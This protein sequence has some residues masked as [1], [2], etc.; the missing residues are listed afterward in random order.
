MLKA[1]KASASVFVFEMGVLAVT[2]S[3]FHYKSAICKHVMFTL[4]LS[5]QPALMSTAF[6][7]WPAKAKL[8][9]I[10]YPHTL[11]LLLHYLA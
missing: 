4:R 7:V 10:E 3:S 9:F 11:L 6:T 8:L 2:K 5:L 1:R